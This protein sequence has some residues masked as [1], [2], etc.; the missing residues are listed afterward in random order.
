VNRERITIFKIRLN[1]KDYIG[2]TYS[3]WGYDSKRTHSQQG[4]Q[5]G[6]LKEIGAK[7]IGSI[8]GYKLDIKGLEGGRWFIRSSKI[9]KTKG[10]K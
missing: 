8:E 3:K 5:A 10:K 9:R 2:Y 1:H 6:L 7:K 4:E